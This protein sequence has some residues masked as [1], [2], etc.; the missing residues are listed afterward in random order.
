MSAEWSSR[1]KSHSGYVTPLHAP[2]AIA[3][4]PAPRKGR[5][6]C[7]AASAHR[8]ARCA[9]VRCILCAVRCPSCVVCCPLHVVRRALCAACCLRVPCHIPPMRARRSKV[10][11]E[12]NRQTRIAA[13]A[14]INS[15]QPCSAR[16]DVRRSLQL[17]SGATT[18]DATCNL[19][20]ATSGVARR[21]RGRRAHHSVGGRPTRK[22]RRAPLAEHR[23]D[24][25]G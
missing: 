14:C 15:A 1:T 9:F 21:T 4:H 22:A 16:H 7:Q 20:H 12:T 17:R 3:R 2:A 5:T 18:P 19:R 10:I 25:P 23:G 8:E 6:P 13:T 24:R 11:R